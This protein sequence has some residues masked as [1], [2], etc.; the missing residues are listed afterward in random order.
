MSGGRPRMTIGRFG[1]IWLAEA[2]GGR[3]ASTRVRDDDG[4]LRRV[5]ATA[6]SKGAAA[7]LLKERIRDRSLQVGRAELG[8]RT[9]FRELVERWLAWDDAH[10]LA[11]KTKQW[12]TELVRSRLLSA[13][14]QFALRE[15]TTARVEAFLQAEYTDGWQRAKKAS[16]AP[17]ASTCAVSVDAAS[18]FLGHTSTAITEGYYIEPSRVVDLTPAAALDRILRPG[19]TDHTMLTMPL[20]DDEEWAIESMLGGSEA[21]AEA[22]ER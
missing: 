16:G 20:S 8:V 13:F 15:I 3:T 2:P 17:S 22:A 10:D 11:P 9:P 18:A 19:A 6:R 14:G 5:K 21:D 12:Y 4:R 7:Q 1:S